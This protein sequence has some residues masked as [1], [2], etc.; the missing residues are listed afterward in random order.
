MDD[1]LEPLDGADLAAIVDLLPRPWLIGV[2][3]DGTLAP[4]VARPED[5]RL[6]PQA[7]NALDQLANRPGA[8]VAVVSGR[9]LA[10][11]RHKFEIPAS[12]MLLGSHGAEI[13]SDVTERT[14]EEQHDIDAALATL[15]AVS[16]RLPGSWIE[17]KPFAVALHVRQA[18]PVQSSVA[19][20]E[21]ELALRASPNLTIHRGH[22]VLEV[23]VRPTSKVDAFGMLRN[24]LEPA[25]TVFVGD[26]HS[27]EKVF[28]SLDPTDIGVK[29]GVGPTVA[30][31]RLSAPDD[32]VAF[33]LA[34]AGNGRPE[35][36]NQ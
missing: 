31:H 13:G 5:S 25:T 19:L 34:L 20:A 30:T 26:D 18:D 29:V 2:D 15:E 24:R 32:V 36:G 17:P 6:A 9:P 1:D 28:G 14:D 10:D 7:L 27:D 8:M 23:A 35:T 4:I 21:L 3:V 33:L 11:L 12:V 16:R 22:M